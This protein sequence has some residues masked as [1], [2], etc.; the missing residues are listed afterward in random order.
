MSTL[1]GLGRIVLPVLDA[2]LEEARI[3]LLDVHEALADVHEYVQAWRE[4]LKV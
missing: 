2:V 1:D 4:L 3:T